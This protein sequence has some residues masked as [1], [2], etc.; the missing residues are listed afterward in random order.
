MIPTIDYIRSKFIEFNTLFFDGKLPEPPF[1]LSRARKTLGQV[2]YRRS[3]GTNGMWHYD[4]FIIR[5]SSCIDMSETE[6]EDTI[7][8]EMIHLWILSNQWTD[9]SAHGM[10]FRH[11]MK[12]LNTRHG[13]HITICH[14][15]AEELEQDRSPRQ[16]FIC[17]T[18][19]SDG[20]CGFT[21][22]VHTRIRPLRRQMSRIPGIVKQRWYVTENPFFNRFS[23]TMK[24]KLYIIK[25]EEL[26]KQLEDARPL[27]C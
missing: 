15:S 7:L 12:E 20:R 6:W 3:H 26:Q 10:L 1:E 24:P 17:V 22:A 11:K 19:L 13:R 18:L 23:R 4:N 14:R 9:S 27:I 8:H 5:I 16:H 2:V 25:E 21:P